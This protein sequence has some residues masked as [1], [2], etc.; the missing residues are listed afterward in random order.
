MTEP[1]A[2]L[3]AFWAGLLS[4]LLPCTLPLLPGYLAFISGLGVEEV[5]ARERTGR[6][7]S[8]AALFVLGF[9]LVFVAL[10]ATLSYIGAFLLPHRQ[11]LT[12]VSG[13]FIIVMALVMVGLLR[14]PIFYQER[15]FH[16]GREFGIWSSFPLG[17]AFAFGWT[18]C[19]GP[20]LTSILAVATTT[21]TAQR[22]ALLLF[23]YALGL[24]VPFIAVALFAGRLFR[25]FTWIKRH[26]LALNLAGGSMLIIMGIFLALDRWTEL[27][28]PLLR[29]Y[30]EHNLLP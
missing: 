20:V 15:R 27:M 4:F 6:V 3:L 7:V 30:A 23:I 28:A 14:V 8:A 24:G 17:M 12:R 5:Q 18:P 9:A 11:F 25:S 13:V 10:G 26:Y 1:A 29:W 19:I 21:G 2:L 22:G 16:L